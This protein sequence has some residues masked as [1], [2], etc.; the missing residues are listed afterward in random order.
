LYNLINGSRD[1]RHVIILLL[2]AI[3]AGTLP[4]RP[5]PTAARAAA[6][7][8]AIGG[9]RGATL[10]RGAR[11]LGP[12]PGP[13]PLRLIV[14][15]TPRH[16]DLLDAF[17]RRTD[18]RSPRRTLSSGDYTRLFGPTAASEGAVMAYLRARGLRIVRRYRDH[19]LLDVVGTAARIA[20]AFGS[21]IVRYRD[22]RGRV[23]YANLT[24]PRLPAA[25]APLV[26]T[27]VG[28]RDDAPRRHGPAPR[29]AIATARIP[30]SVNDRPAT[31]LLGSGASRPQSLRPACAAMCLGVPTRCAPDGVPR[32]PRAARSAAQWRRP[33]LALTVSVVNNSRALTRTTQEVWPRHARGVPPPPPTQLTPIGIQAAYD[34]AP[35]YTTVLT[36]TNG[37][38]TT[39]VI[40]GG[41]QTIALYEL[42]PFD[43]KDIAAYDAA[44]GIAAAPPISIPVD[45]GAT[46]AYGDAGAQETALDIELAQAVAPGA[47]IL[48]YNGPATPNSAD[49]AAAD[50]IYARIIDDGKAQVLSTSWGQCEDAA[51]TDQP[52][53]F[54]LLHNLFTQAVAE[55]MTVVAASGDNGAYDCLSADG[56][57]PDVTKQTVDYPASDPYAIAVGGTQLALTASGGIASEAGW[58]GSGGG[59]SNTFAR[60][61]WQTGPGVD[62]LLSNGKRQVPDV[63]LDAGSAYAVWLRG[64]RTQGVGT[65]AATPIWAGLLALG[66]QLRYAVAG[67]A[68]A[69][70][71]T[72]ATLPGLGD[73]HQELYQ[74]AA[75]PNGTPAFRD[76]TTGSSNGFAAA[77][78]GWDY[79][80][81]L[82]APDATV[83][84]HALVALPA[85][86][87]P[88]P[89]ACPTPPPMPTPPPTITPLP[90]VTPTA[91]PTGA[92][93]P[94]PTP[95]RPAVTQT[96]GARLV[97]RVVPGQVAPG[98][99]IWLELSGA[100]GRG[101]KVT[102]EL[103]YPTGPWRIIR[104]T[105]GL[106]AVKVWVR[107]PRTFSTR[108]AIVVRL[109]ATVRQNKRTM[110]VQTNLVVLQQLAVRR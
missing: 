70:P 28:L 90:R 63:A 12:L 60:P 91:S 1:R 102:F 110:S 94:V 48:V 106:G 54:A 7:M 99:A 9:G 84:L 5:V 42:S 59:L 95:T 52:P 72:C 16:Q 38:T 67:A 73:I 81:G 34:I 22:T 15:L 104:V 8:A 107:V 26:T 71:S 82:G 21:P 53:D 89:G 51:Q 4:P 64:W 101:L 41:G 44:F 27:V 49:T 105:D 79:V 29:V 58:A 23:Y 20:D 33:R 103:D 96:R 6:T 77:G 31:C 65:S 75:A 46:D 69:A 74:L 11:V 100:M 61:A 30:G 2:L 76:I 93:K 83:L 39:T 14:G 86:A 66:N 97:V 55:G 50:D 45:G 88:T 40:T 80:T 109:R 19:L 36:S 13:T 62:N 24:W 43:P 18:V 17:L 92:R 78:P 32:G 85:L 56:M 47:R 35:L 87:P 68:G 3:V 57:T 25:L 37:L 108:R 10:P 98:G